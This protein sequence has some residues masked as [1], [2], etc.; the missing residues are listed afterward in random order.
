MENV[1]STA[2]ETS[3]SPVLL[4]SA[5]YRCFLMALL[6]PI[7]SSSRLH[8]WLLSLPTNASESC[9]GGEGGGL[10]LC[11]YDAEKCNVVSTGRDHSDQFDRRLVYGRDNGDGA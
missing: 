8:E 7:T 9:A 10:I 1:N 5:P 6:L 11:E 4:L 2:V 3:M